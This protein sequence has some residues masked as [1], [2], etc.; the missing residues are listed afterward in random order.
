MQQ[1]ICKDSIIGLFYSISE[2]K[3]NEKENF[4]VKFMLRQHFC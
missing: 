3:K 1:Y 4:K 2:S